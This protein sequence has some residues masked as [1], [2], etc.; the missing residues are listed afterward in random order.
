MPSHD[1]VTYELQVERFSCRLLG[2]DVPAWPIKDAL[3]TVH[4]FEALF[5]SARA[6]GWVPLE[7]R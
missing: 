7:T 6:G 2:E 4:T 5:E 1:D 3:D